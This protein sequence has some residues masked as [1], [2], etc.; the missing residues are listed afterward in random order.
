MAQVQ[1][2]VEDRDEAL[3]FFSVREAAR[4]RELFRKAHAKLGRTVTVVGDRAW[5]DDG[6]EM[7]LW[8]LA[9]DCH[10][11]PQAMWPEILRDQIGATQIDPSNPFEGMS[12]T[13]ILRNVY[14]KLWWASAL[15]DVTWFPHARAVAPGLVELPSVHVRRTV[16]PMRPCDIDHYGGLDTLRRTGRD[17]LADLPVEQREMIETPEGGSFRVL[18]GQSSFTASRILTLERLVSQ[19]FLDPAMPYGVLAAVPNRN[20]VAVHII[21]DDTAIPTIVNLATFA[22]L[23]SSSAPGP[24]SP[25]VYWVTPDRFEQVGG[26]DDEGRFQILYSPEFRDTMDGMLAATRKGPKEP[27]RASGPM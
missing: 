2:E 16:I 9:A 3:P 10:T 6:S 24:L 23:R 22:R 27:P 15:P 26:L 18:L 12:R 19:L 8:N 17:N 13:Q 5:G 25:H 7:G 4:F 20:E 11:Y 1:R 21:K 14:L